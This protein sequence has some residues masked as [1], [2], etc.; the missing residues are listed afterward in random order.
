MEST[1]QDVNIICKQINM[2]TNQKDKKKCNNLKVFQNACQCGREEA[3]AYQIHKT[4]HVSF[5]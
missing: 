3:A 1:V 4:V 5:S 2:Q